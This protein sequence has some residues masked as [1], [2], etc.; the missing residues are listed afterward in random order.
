MN[1]PTYRTGPTY[2]VMASVTLLVFAA[3]GC[4]EAQASS[5]NVVATRQ[6]LD[7]KDVD[8]VA[9]ECGLV[10]PGDTTKDGVKVRGVAEGNAAIAGVSS[11]DAFFA[12]VLHFQTASQ[13]VSD[14]IDTQ[15]AAIRTDFGLAAN[16]DIV[17][18]LTARFAANAE[19]GVKIEHEPPR[20]SADVKATLDAQA[21]CDSTFEPG[22]AMLAC[23]GDC[24]LEASAS[25]SCDAQSDLECTL[26]APSIACEGSCSGACEAQLTAAAACDGT[27]KGSCDG[28]CSAY[29]MDAS[30]KAQCAGQC[31]GM[32]TGSCETQ[33]AGTASCSGKCK[34]ECV[35][36]N[37]SAGCTG[38]V[39]VKCKARAN[40]M[41]M[42]SG[43]C[44]S[45]F[46]PPK[47]KAEC[48]A[49]VKADAKCHM[50]CSPPRVVAR[51]RARAAASAALAER[52]RFAAA[53]KTLAE[54]RLPA[55]L[56]Q[57]Q[58]GTLVVQAGTELISAAQGAVRGSVNEALSGKLSVQEAFGLRC[59]VGELP[60]VDAIVNASNQRLNQSL[61]SANALTTMLGG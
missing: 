39:S 28:T 43:R 18:E 60:K 42:C 25:A 46:E 59:A 11:V 7:L 12:S 48:Q 38:A 33:L 19:A 9:K 58:Q 32:C 1:Q 55:L 51:Y 3:A 61:D 13:S 15:I 23:K 34:G 6:A 57:T 49:S 22:K 14:G 37:P 16:A 5:P 4:D 41:V 40:A 53:V 26:N 8:E 50:H 35:V 47:A 44:E 56:A 52:A 30:G 20:C 24:E 54:V 10:C 21:R 29:A 45:D 27:C 17:T 2:C 36:M 31:S